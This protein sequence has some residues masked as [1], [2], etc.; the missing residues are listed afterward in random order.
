MQQV[1]YF[2]AKL[3]SIPPTNTLNAQKHVSHFKSGILGNWGYG[4]LSFNSYN[5]NE[6]IFEKNIIDSR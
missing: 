2:V 3:Y 6:N 1:L 4:R 5:G